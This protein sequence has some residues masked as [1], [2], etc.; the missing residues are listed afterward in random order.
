MKLSVKISAV[1]GNVGNTA[2]SD[3]SLVHPIGAVMSADARHI[4]IV[5]LFKIFIFFFFKS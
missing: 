3:N 2:S 1:F 5:F 4:N